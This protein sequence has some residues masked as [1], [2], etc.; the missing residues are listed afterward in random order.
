MKAALV[1]VS[2]IMA[3]FCMAQALPKKFAAINPGTSETDVIK[4]V[5]E[6]KQIERFST[7]R[8]NSYDTTRYWRY[9]KDIIIVFTNHAVETIEPQWETLL[10]KIQQR[11]NRKDEDG[12][13]II[14]GE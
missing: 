10:K 12:I 5:G 14:S 2:L 6:P 9:E 7:V 11:A 3:N 13:K 8:N 4:Q 1:L